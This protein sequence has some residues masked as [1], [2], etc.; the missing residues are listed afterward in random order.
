VTLSQPGLS[1]RPESANQQARGRWLVAISAICGGIALVE[2]ALWMPTMEA[3]ARMLRPPE[4]DAIPAY[5]GDVSPFQ[6]AALA[7]MTVIVIASFLAILMI[8][9]LAVLLGRRARRRLGN[10]AMVARLEK[11]AVACL[12]VSLLGL[13]FTLI[14][15]LSSLPAILSIRM[16]L[17]PPINQ[18]LDIMLYRSPVIIQVLVAVTAAGAIGCIILSSIAAR[19]GQRW[20]TPVGLVLSALIL[21]AWFAS[22]AWLARFI[23]GFYLHLVW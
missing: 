7:R 15:S 12:I 19:R 17:P 10:E 6:Q 11:W 8:A 21:L 22:T 9:A 20:R 3:V 23:V 18:L 16:R 1:P 2:S 5:R 4:L 13:G 14:V